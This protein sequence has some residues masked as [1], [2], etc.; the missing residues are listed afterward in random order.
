MKFKGDW[1]KIPQ[2]KV[3][4]VLCKTL[5][6]R[7][8]SEC[9]NMKKPQLK[10]CEKKYLATAMVL[11]EYCA[12]FAMPMREKTDQRIKKLSVCWFFVKTCG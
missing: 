11:F 6:P 5:R 2:S 12:A 4:R 3:L 9:M 8:I 1:G 7:K 10:Q